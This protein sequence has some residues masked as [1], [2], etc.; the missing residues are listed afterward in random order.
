MTCLSSF[1]AQACS[2]FG[3]HEIN[4]SVA[5]KVDLVLCTH[6]FWDLFCLAEKP[7][8]F[9]ISQYRGSWRSISLTIAMV[10]VD[11]RELTVYGHCVW[12][13]EVVQAGSGWKR[14]YI[15]KIIFF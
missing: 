5:A 4:P 12:T 9:N 14:E 6:T 13:P 10:R 3:S 11:L 2:I 15:Y 1:I 7:L 8:L